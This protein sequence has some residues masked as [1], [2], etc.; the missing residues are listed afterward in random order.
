MRSA[1]RSSRCETL[2]G[3]RAGGAWSTLSGNPSPPR[4][5][6]WAES[7]DS[8][9]YS[10]LLGLFPSPVPE[11]LPDRMPFEVRELTRVKE[12]AMAHWA[13]FHPD[14]RLRR[15]DHPNHERSIRRAEHL[16]LNVVHRRLPPGPCIDGLS[17]RPVTQLLMFQ[18]IKP[19]AAAPDTAIDFDVLEHNHFHLGL[20]LGAFHSRT[21]CV[22]S[23]CCYTNR[24]S[25][26]MGLALHGLDRAATPSMCAS[27]LVP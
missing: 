25:I 13:G 4:Q 10:T 12:G 23:V 19:E 16:P 20:A 11:K 24:I 7:Q 2:S 5:E 26:C 21:F 17:A 9:L 22:A 14:V 15:I 3:S 6:A 8:R 18:N 1:S 27:R